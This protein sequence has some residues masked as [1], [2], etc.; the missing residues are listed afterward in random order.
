MD[1]QTLKV[2]DRV[3]IGAATA[4]LMSCCSAQASQ[5]WIGYSPS[6]QIELSIKDADGE[7]VASLP[8][9]RGV[10]AYVLVDNSEAT[11]LQV[12]GRPTHRMRSPEAISLSPMPLVSFDAG[13]RDLIESLSRLAFDWS[14]SRDRSAVVRELAEKVDG[15]AGCS[16]V[17][18]DANVALGWA[19]LGVKEL[20]AALATG[21]RL[22][23]RCGEAVL[24]ADLYG[25]WLISESEMRRGR[26]DHANRGYAR[27]VSLIRVDD[28]PAE[29]R[30]HRL[31]VRGNWAIA[32]IEHAYTQAG[33]SGIEECMQR[34]DATLSESDEAGD[35][36]LS[37]ELLNLMAPYHWSKRDYLA[38]GEVLRL[39]R[40]MFELA[41]TR[42]GLGGT[43]NNLALN[44]GWLGNFDE[45]QALFR[46]ALNLVE[47]PDQRALV[48]RN[49]ARNY[50]LVG[51]LA[52][53]ERYHRRSLEAFA[54]A[55]S[56]RRFALAE[57]SLGSVLRLLGKPEEA[58][59][60]HRSALAYFAD[61]SSAQRATALFEL[62]QDLLALGRFSEA[63][64]SAAQAQRL[65]RAS[66]SAVLHYKATLLAAEIELRAGNLSKAHVLLAQAEHR[67]LADAPL[68]AR[69][70]R[71][72]LGLRIAAAESD[73]ARFDE[74]G[75]RLLDLVADVRDDLAGGPV[76]LQWINQTGALVDRYLE[77]ILAGGGDLDLARVFEIVE[78]NRAVALRARRQASV[79]ETPPSP[80]AAEQQRSRLRTLVAAESRLASAP[81]AERA[82]A[83]IAVDEAREAYQTTRAGMAHRQAPLPELPFVSLAQAQAALEHDQAMV[84]FHAGSLASF[85]IVITHDQANLRPLGNAAELKGS[86]GNFR[87]AIQRDE[88]HS[89]LTIP[90]L[91]SMFTALLE[92]PKIQHVVAVTDGAVSQLPLSAVPLAG[93]GYRPLG[94]AVS[95]VYTPSA[96]VFLDPAVAAG[97]FAADIAI[98]ADPAFD[99]RDLAAVGTNS[100][101][102][103]WSEGLGRLPHTATEARRIAERFPTLNIAVVTGEQATSSRL[104]EPTYTKSRI[105][106]IAT[107]GYY[108]PATP[109]IVGLATAPDTVSGE[110]GFLSLSRLHALRYG[111][112]LVVISGCE[113]ALGESI[114]GEGVNG[115]ARAVLAQGA[116]SVIGTLWP[117]SDAATAAFMSEFYRRLAE[118]GG[119]ASDAL[120]GA[121]AH[122]RASHRYR[123]P[124][125]WAGFV[126]L[127]AGQSYRSV[128][129]P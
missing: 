118:N 17:V 52:L 16:P 38:A 53:A 80:A 48:M 33:H 1:S 107:H 83:R 117:V 108:D 105:V 70:Q 20:E 57:S 64:G 93:G 26:F 73:A 6:Q 19:Q 46:E 95:M 35:Y 58:L 10:R 65:A 123:A 79:I 32:C 5:V 129:A 55:G 113:T 61:E 120:H 60:L 54:S 112:R 86:V 22:V 75:Q 99:N 9:P 50:E 104:V 121:Q 115:L 30:W 37:A 44:E 114:R 43:L 90:T 82:A 13:D 45:A 28:L 100:R 94:A 109:D 125:Y 8:T 111:A 116:D 56:P 67:P 124:R 23:E 27:L 103:D 12:S 41:E 127:V 110:P 77:G 85:A 98:F 15:S 11:E 119:D 91:E 36:K 18:V 78:R 24:S 101:F 21:R 76:E 69:L 89:A 3:I 106:H 88:I 62:A 92:D 59:R 2:Q 39:S 74:E 25:R 47:V 122:F 96:S 34:L 63:R 128:L 7:S 72:E 81:E 42:D 71:I 97:P 126:M 66:N 51:D 14:S 49:L 102:R 87:D 31:Q 40:L 84:V 68:D 29:W 4:A